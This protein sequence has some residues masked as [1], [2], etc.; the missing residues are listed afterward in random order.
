LRERSVRYSEITGEIEL[1]RAGQP[2]FPAIWPP[3][4]FKI[5]TFAQ[6]LR[7]TRDIL[8]LSANAQNLLRK[9][10]QDIPA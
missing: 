10:G 3:L 2:L 4:F 1:F 6:F 8:T 5:S 7:K 9:V